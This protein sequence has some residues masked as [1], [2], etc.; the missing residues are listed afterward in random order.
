MADSML[1]DRYPQQLRKAFF[2]DT[3][4]ILRKHRNDLLS[5]EEARRALRANQQLP[6]T[7]ETIPVDKIVGSVGRY[8]DF[9]RAF[10]PRKGASAERWRRLDRA[11][12][13]METIPPIEVYQLGDVYFVRDGNHRVSVARA[14]GV[15]FIE[16]RVTRLT[17]RVPLTTDAAD[18][19]EIIREYA[20]FLDKTN[21]DHL[22]P[23]QRIWFSTQG[24]YKT[25]LEHIAVHQY[26]MGQERGAA[27]PY[28][29]A[30]AHWYDE[31]YEPI[32]EAIRRHR[33][34]DQFPGRTEADLYL[35]L[36]DHQYYLSERYGPGVSADEAAEHFVEEYGGPRIIRWLRATWRRLWRRR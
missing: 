22:R 13:R 14:N 16:A 27:V 21:L 35:W 32:V 20:D 8:K 31:V 12:E 19:L 15:K 18:Q 30:V 1:P 23:Q 26:F 11:L 17:S 33:V 28:A 29:E 36:V 3:L 5:F 4:A 25:L 2:D 7:T 24:H 34:L 9:T 6:P 10:L